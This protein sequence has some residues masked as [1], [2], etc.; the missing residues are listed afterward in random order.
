MCQSI[1]ADIIRTCYNINDNNFQS[2]KGFITRY[3]LSMVMA[4]MGEQLTQDEIEV[5]FGN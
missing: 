5:G 4:Y 3:E 2:G 1:L